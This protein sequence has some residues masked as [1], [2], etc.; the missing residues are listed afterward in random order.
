MPA[1]ASTEYGALHCLDLPLRAAG[2]ASEDL[3][4]REEGDQR[5]QQRHAAQERGH[6]EG[7]T[8]G[9]LHRVAAHDGEV[10]AQHRRGQ[11][12]RERAPRDRR[13]AA[14]AEEA[15]DGVFHGGERQGEARQQR[16]GDG[17]D[18][19]RHDAAGH[20]GQRGDHQRAVRLALA[21]QGVAVDRGGRV[22]GRAR[23]VEQ[24]RRD[25]AREVARAVEREEQRHGLLERQHEG[26]RRQDGDARGR[27]E[28]RQCAEGEP[29][30]DAGQEPAPDR[31]VRE[32]PEPGAQ[33]VHCGRSTSRP[34]RNSSQ[35]PSATAGG[36]RA[37]SMGRRAPSTS[38]APSVKTQLSRR[39]STRAN[40]SP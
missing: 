20:R 15:E 30:Q 4:Q 36:N 29:E 6:A 14:Q 33:G 32:D 35:V 11:A 8:I 24:D 23:Q 7:Q 17:E 27:G 18:E 13:H 16:S 12:T 21:R 1:P 38:M 19:D 31:G 5:R 2:D 39:K 9:T 37:S 34:W 40:S 26:Q 3:R 25:R 28:P 10:E 22:A